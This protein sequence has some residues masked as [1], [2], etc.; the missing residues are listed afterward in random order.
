MAS[1]A[2]AQRY[3][4]ALFELADGQVC[5]DAV[6]AE[7]DALAPLGRDRELLAFAREPRIPASQR[8]GVLLHALRGRVS[9]LTVSFARVVLQ[10]G[11]L[12]LLPAIAVEFGRLLDRSRNRVR[13]QVRSAV[14][15]DPAQEQEL[16][17]RLAQLT[18]RTIVL[19][20]AVEPALIGGLVITAEG[21]QIDG[22]VARAFRDLRERLQGI[23]I[24]TQE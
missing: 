8:E 19:E 20:T 1:A 10:H 16:N 21:W 3:A 11:R 18:G 2:V 15:L 9:D 14:P 4:Q 13:A 22:S 23:S 7:L 5:T 12:K 17:D 24:G 6:A